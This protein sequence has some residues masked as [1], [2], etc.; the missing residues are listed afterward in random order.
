[1]QTQYKTISSMMS[2]RAR[3]LRSCS[4]SFP[5]FYEGMSTAEY[6]RQYWGANA[7]NIGIECG[8]KNEFQQATRAARDF[9][10]PL[11]P[12]PATLPQGADVIKELAA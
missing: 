5:K 7:R 11:N 3:Q 4:R 9:F 2:A 6:V 8:Y 12:C 10:E 1:M